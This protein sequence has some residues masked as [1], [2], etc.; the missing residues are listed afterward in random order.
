VTSDDSKR[1]TLSGIPSDGTLSAESVSSLVQ[2]DAASRSDSARKQGM[3]APLAATLAVQTCATEGARPNTKSSANIETDDSW[4]DPEIEAALGFLSERSPVVAAD[5]GQSEPEEATR[6]FERPALSPTASASE[7]PKPSSAPAGIL[8]PNARVSDSSRSR[9]LPALGELPGS[10]QATSLPQESPALHETQEAPEEPTRFFHRPDDVG[11]AP[12]ESLRA[13]A[14]QS[15]IGTVAG[16]SNRKLS[17]EAKPLRPKAEL[18]LSRVPQTPPTVDSEGEEATQFFE[19]ASFGPVLPENAPKPKPPELPKKSEPPRP[20]TPHVPGSAKEPNRPPTVS[21]TA[22]ASA[23]GVDPV[24]PSNVEVAAQDAALESQ[25]SPQSERSFEPVAQ[26]NPRAVLGQTAVTAFSIAPRPGS[27]GFESEPGIEPWNVRIRTRA[28]ASVAAAVVCGLVLSAIDAWYARASA[29]EHPAWSKLYLGAVGLAV[30]TTIAVGCVTAAVTLL[31]HPDYPPSFRGFLTR[32]RPLDIRRRSRLA[33]FAL[34]VPLAVAGWLVLVARAA[35]P[36]LGAVG[37]HK[38]IGLVMATL[39]VGLGMLVAAPVLAL[40]RYMGIK[41]RKNPPDPVRWALFGVVLGTAPILL[42]IALGHTSGAGGMFGVWG[43]FKRPELDLRLPTMLLIVAI[44]AYCAPALLARVKTW[45]LVVVALLPLLLTLHAGRT[46]L[47]ERSVALAIERG[48]PLGRLALGALRRLTDRDKDGF[49]SR[50]GGGDC[51]D[52]DRNINPTADDLPGN[53]IDEDCSGR[54]SVPMRVARGAGTPRELLAQRREGI[55]RDL[56]L[57]LITID[58]LRADVLEHQRRVTPHLDALLN[59]AVVFSNAYSPASYTGKSVGPILIGKH[60]SETNRDFSHFN[61]FARGKDTFIQ[62]RLQAA[63]IHTTSVQGY[64]YFFQ[65]QYGFDQGF[66]VVDASASSGTGYVEGD[67]TSTSEKLADAVLTQLGKPEMSAN[68]FFLWTHFTDPHVEYVPHA[69]FDFGST[70]FERYLGEAAFVDHH[71]GRIIDYIRAQPWGGRT[72]IVVTS[73][74]GEA[75]GEHGMIR[76]GFEVWEPLVKVPLVFAVPG[77]EPR[78]VTARRS[79]IDVAATIVDLM[80][81]SGASGEGPDFFSGSSLL[82][83]LLGLDGAQAARPFIVDMASGPFNAERQAYFS[84]DLKLITSQSRPL[85]L[86][87]LANDPEEKHDLLD[88]AALK[89]RVLGE[90]RAYKRTMRVVEVKGKSP[91]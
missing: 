73:D 56:N 6:F 76:H 3:K 27:P 38:A 79:I 37:A 72:A 26:D 81:V 90:Y 83:E 59:S 39:T 67:R 84:A 48:A 28:T 9:A 20:S 31:L 68:R 63:G 64:W 77:I 2:P 52:R 57:I 43:V 58:T 25:P 24:S 53:G 10:K 91:Q 61:A 49:S 50:F 13:T 4:D 17:P 22:T 55:P 19:R 65:P 40:A 69:G 8:E 12:E 34:T 89:E 21:G 86:Y 71:V 45:M 32:F 42:A 7:N 41:M 14:T 75:F 78:R 66:S 60:S 15:N 23:Q 44:A 29:A 1:S 33:V 87:D 88:D 47:N 36:L 18:E 70:S 51:N 16:L 35:L 46:G 30:P 85:G 80:Q 82:P 62:Q 74:H 5:P 11:T 54:D